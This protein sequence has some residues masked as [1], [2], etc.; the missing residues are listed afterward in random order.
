L[1][2]TVKRRLKTLIIGFIVP[3]FFVA[4]VLRIGWIKNFVDILE[5]FCYDQLFISHQT[6]PD[7]LV[8]IDMET[9][10]P[11]F[12]ERS[13]CAKLIENLQ[14]DSVNVIGFDILFTDTLRSEE[15]NPLVSITNTSYNVIHA[16]NLTFMRRP[17]RN[18]TI[19]NNHALNLQ[20][21]PR[22]DYREPASGV[23]L[24]FEDLYIASKSL[25]NI[26]YLPDKDQGDRHF[27]L[28]FN[29]G[30]HI[31][32]S[33]PLQIVKQFLNI[34]D[35]NFELHFG[36]HECPEIH[37]DDFIA[38]K[39][40]P[41]KFIKIPVD[42]LGEVLIHFIGFNK[43]KRYSIDN[44]L[45][46]LNNPNDS[47]FK[48]KIVLIV[49][50]GNVTDYSRKNPLGELLPNWVIHASI[51][52]Q[53]LNANY[54]VESEWA[55]NI[56]IFV[57]ILIVLSWLTLIEIRLT[58]LKNKSI[59]ILLAIWLLLVI[60]SCIRLYYGVW[61][62]II[63][64]GAILSISYLSSRY[65]LYKEKPVPLPRYIDFELQIQEKT[66][67]TYLVDVI[68]SPVGEEAE[69]E[70]KLNMEETLDFV[71]RLHTFSTTREEVKKFGTLLFNSLFQKQTGR[72][73]DESLGI[74]A[75]DEN[76]NLRIKLR[77]EPPELSTLPW[78]LLYDPVRRAH[79]VLSNELSLV[80]Y[81][82]IPQK[83][84]TMAIKPPLKIL[85]ILSN[86][87]DV[88]PLD[89][90][91]EKARIIKALRKLIWKRQVK[92]RF[93]EKATIDEIK[94]HIH[95]YHVIHFIGHGEYK[96]SP[97]G[98]KG[99]LVFENDNGKKQL[100][101]AETLRVLFSNTPVRLFVLNACETAKSST[102]DAFLGVA[103]NL[104]QAGI[105]AVIAMQFEV[106]DQS[107][108][109]FSGEFYRSLAK[110]FQIDAAITDAR[111]SLAITP[112]I[113]RIDWGV[114]VLFMRSPDGVLFKQR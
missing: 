60:I 35:N 100:I 109:V 78:E 22:F 56:F 34:T 49:N 69:G 48:N 90:K 17:I 57:S 75:N 50:S 32:P 27:P 46:L 29:Y 70:F 67:S 111:K 93:L 28:V 81:L 19:L 68:A 40:P 110:N 92:L 1:V 106:P 91:K 85:I 108:I 5:Y 71:K 72:R 51:I 2:P 86:P 21:M 38:L 61:I 33:L 113:D 87:S 107:A 43:F 44:A 101:D 37:A 58:W 74:V 95:K 62:C 54:I 55:T 76:E 36:N 20:I 47:T 96:E 8:I 23:E 98:S 53:I 89:I 82:L 84:K 112:G 10:S 45:D 11:H 102:Y 13:K 6:P 83:T 25:A 31:Y 103:P 99:R 39:A 97:V 14:K 9:S 79:L 4:I 73:F 66:K 65:Y 94:K 18:E 52:S 64:P 15:D 77:I 63:L 3:L 88:I 80:R 30:N 12:I 59:L 42:Y 26:S 114:P 41:N 24:P 104:V 105:P 7:Q 16:F